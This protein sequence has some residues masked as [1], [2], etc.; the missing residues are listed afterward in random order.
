MNKKIIISVII[1]IL[2]FVGYRYIYHAK[3]N[4]SQESSSFTMTLS[5]LDNDLAKGN[6]SFNKKLLDKT[7]EISG[8]ITKIESVDNSIVIDEKIFATFDTVSKPV[9]KLN[10]KIIIKGR[11]LGY[12]DLLEIYKFDQVVINK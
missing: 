3:R 1:L 8:T 5:A 10:Q 12:D 11:F 9:T 7:I 4:I 2:L 6:E